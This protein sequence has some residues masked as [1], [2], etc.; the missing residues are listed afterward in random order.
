MDNYFNEDCKLIVDRRL[1]DLTDID[2]VYHSSRL[3]RRDFIMSNVEVGDILYSPTD[4]YDAMDGGYY[5][6]RE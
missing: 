6:K 3:K 2:I 5:K 1:F 4:G